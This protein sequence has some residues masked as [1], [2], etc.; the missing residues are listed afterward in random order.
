MRLAPRCAVSAHPPTRFQ[1][2][3]RHPTPENTFTYLS[4]FAENASY[5]HRQLYH[6]LSHIWCRTARLQRQH[7]GQT[8]KRWQHQKRRH[9][10]R[11]EGSGCEEFAMLHLVDCIALKLDAMSAA[12]RARDCLCGRL[13]SWA[14]NFDPGAAGPPTGCAVTIAIV[15]I[16]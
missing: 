15:R 4:S 9:N 2:S 13:S 8:W 16:V 12:S 14:G 1:R 7:I 5:R 10:S 6:N 3:T 11:Q